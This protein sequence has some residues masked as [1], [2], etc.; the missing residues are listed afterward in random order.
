MELL[1]KEKKLLSDI[2][3]NTS[4][5][6]D[7]FLRNYG[8]EKYGTMYKGE[9]PMVG[10]E[11]KFYIH[12]ES[13]SNLKKDISQ[14]ETLIRKNELLGYVI[15]NDTDCPDT[16]NEKAFFLYTQ[17]DTLE[18][19]KK[20]QKEFMR[21][22][23]TRTDKLEVL[24]KN[25]YKSNEEMAAEAMLAEKVNREK[26]ERKTF[27]I[28]VC[29][30]VATLLGGLISGV[31]GSCRSKAIQEIKMINKKEEPVYV[32]FDK[33]EIN[34]LFIK[35]NKLESQNKVLSEQIIELREEKALQKDKMVKE[36]VQKTK[37]K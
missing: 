29:S 10:V 13:E 20:K 2:S 14:F 12:E 36:S 22:I 7:F 15:V 26:A 9:R 27:I 11:W 23:V 25:D 18:W 24:I 16:T 5:L 33:K 21:K 31:V 19:L 3:H 6:W 17:G 32:D 28:A 1:E 34:E 30:M 35:I 37:E 8:L 4:S